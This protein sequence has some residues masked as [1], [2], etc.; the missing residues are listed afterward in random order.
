MGRLKTQRSADDDVRDPA[1][2][3]APFGFGGGAS[4]AIPVSLRGRCRVVITSPQRLFL[5]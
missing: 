4:K 5:Q 1:Q 3:R 2:R